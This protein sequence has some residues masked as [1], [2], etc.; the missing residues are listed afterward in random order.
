LW[1]LSAARTAG[2]VRL[3]EAVGLAE[4]AIA[5]EDE[6]ALADEE[7]RLKE[8]YQHVL[9]ERTAALAADA[10]LERATATAAW[11]SAA[12]AASGERMAAVEALQRKTESLGQALSK[13][14]QLAKEVTVDLGCIRANNGSLPISFSLREPHTPACPGDGRASG[15]GRGAGEGA[16]PCRRRRRTLD[17]RPPA[18]LQDHVR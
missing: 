1:Q 5:A 8:Y 15:G 18:H 14:T 3:T 13:N 10:T 2:E 4:A 9:D 16:R 11:A 12:A 17:R 7:A 6:A